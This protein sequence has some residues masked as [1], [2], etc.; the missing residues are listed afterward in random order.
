MILDVA[1]LLH[2]AAEGSLCIRASCV[3]E[4]PEVLG[5][6]IRVDPLSNRTGGVAATHGERLDE[7]M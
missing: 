4:N 6:G 7:K 1:R 2:E 5:L 3:K